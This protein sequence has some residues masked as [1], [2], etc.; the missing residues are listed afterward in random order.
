M[1]QTG[2]Q[3]TLKGEYSTTLE[4]VYS[5]NKAM[6]V[7]HSINL[8]DSNKVEIKMAYQNDSQPEFYQMI[9][10]MKGGISLNNKGGFANNFEI[11]AQQHNLCKVALKSTIMVMDS[12]KDEVICINLSKEFL[13][14]YIPANHLAY[15]QLIL[16][17]GEGGPSVLSSANLPITPEISSIVQRLSTSDSGD[18]HEQLLLESKVIELLALQISQ[19]EQ[20]QNNSVPVLLKP[21]EVEKMQEAREILISNTGEQ[22]SLKSLALRV[23]T[24]EFNLKRDFKMLFG[25]T[26]YGYLNQYKMEQAKSMV[27]ENEFTIAEISEKIGYKHATH[28]TSAFKK[29]FGY[30]PNKLRSGKLSLLIFAD[31]F[32]VA[33][34]NIGC[35]VGC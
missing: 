9:F 31:E 35:F 28:F 22:L 11:G 30:L 2:E 23:G 5:F 20:V 21:V 33:F 15:Q 16:L 6:T 19:F 4:S 29:Y 32:M 24:N 14:R 7:S 12:I 26:V 17:K 3:T 8:G 27:I 1:T 18:F 10:V 13:R 25:N 34:E